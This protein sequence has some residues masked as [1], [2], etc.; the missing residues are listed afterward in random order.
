MRCHYCEADTIM[1][2]RCPF[3]GGYFCAEH[4]LPE[5][6]DCPQIRKAFGWVV[7]REAGGVLSDERPSRGFRVALPRVRTVFGFSSKEA[8]HLIIGSAIVIGVG[9]SMFFQLSRIFRARPEVLIGLALIFTATFIFHEIA[10]KMMAQHYG[11]WAEFRLTQLGAMLTLIS[12][13]L[14]IKVI[15]P[16]VIRI[17]GVANKES[18]GKISLAGPVTNLMLSMVFL[19]LNSYF[20]GLLALAGAVLNS[21]AA[22]FNLIPFSVFDGE[23]VFRWNRKVWALC[24]LISFILMFLALRLFF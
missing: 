11:L 3:C 23:K 14:P 8:K 5:M 2:F 18:V 16:G 12:I 22:F 9:L 21:W 7:G 15:S 10:H 4:R 20:G 24:F 1:P 6:H 19:V 17:V 13:F